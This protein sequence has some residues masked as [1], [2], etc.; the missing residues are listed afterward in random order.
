MSVGFLVQHTEMRISFHRLTSAADQ[1]LVELHAGDDVTVMLFGRL[2]YRADRLE[3]LAADCNELPT[4]AELIAKV[5]GRFGLSG[6]ERLEGEF[7]LVVWDQR[8]QKLIGLRDPL[9]SYPLFWSKRGDSFAISTSLLHLA[10]EH[11][12]SKVDQSFVGRFLM[13]SGQVQELPGTETAY[14][15]VQRVE[16][17]SILV[18]SRSTA[19]ETR[20]YWNWESHVSSLPTEN[21][22]LLGEEYESLL[23]A[24][25]RQRLH[26][27]VAAHLSGGMDSTAVTLL[28]QQENRSPLHAISLVYS[29]SDLSNE[30][31]YLDSVL[32]DHPDLNC[33]KVLADEIQDFDG[34][35]ETSPHDEPYAGLWRFA[36][37]R[38][39]VQAAIDCGAKS[40]LT[41]IGA[42]EML[43]PSPLGIADCLSRG[44]LWGAWK[45]ATRWAAATNCSPWLFLRH[46]GVNAACPAPLMAGFRAWFSGGYRPWNQQSDWTIAP[47]INHSFSRQYG[48]QG[49]SAEN[50]RRLYGRCRP[51]A[52]SLAL[53][54]IESRTGDVDRWLLGAPSGL[55]ISHP[56][57]DP[58]VLSFGLKLQLLRLD[59]SQQ[60]PVLAQATRNILPQ[61]ILR[62][63][64]KGDFSSVYFRGLVRNLPHL[65]HLVA[66][67]PLC[68]SVID[69][70]QLLDC[71]QQAALGA[72]AKIGATHRL[73]TTLC[74]LRWY[75]GQAEWLTSRRTPVASLTIDCRHHCSSAA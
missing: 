40:L 22:E 51:K 32:R 33:H 10:A 24:A 39:S 64:S 54:A 56:F 68:D 9:G 31:A 4:D 59:P 8:Q 62:R 57:L 7:A 46:S 6:L 38:A 5:Y 47:W 61:E 13:L 63:R 53:A 19:L 15:G 73:N 18:A 23:R 71:L 25:V 37:D 34:F 28:A 20:R 11:Q 2:H 50:A 60:K 14:E 58:R 65:Q 69:R 49:H 67:S 75:A 72:S 35:V 43:V 48:L 17:G 52:V 16:A 44:N 55:S 1:T 45:E 42:D 12:R 21:L 26:G 27:T 66:T 29:Q 74:L 70:K 30:S 3:E 36:M 41:G